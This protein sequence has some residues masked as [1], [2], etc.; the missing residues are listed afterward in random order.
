MTTRP[1]VDIDWE[2][3]VAETRGG[4]KADTANLVLLVKEMRAA[5]GSNYGISMALA[6]DLWYLRYFDAAA[7]QPYLDWFGFMTY[8]LH[9]FWDGENAN[10]GSIVRGQAGI[11]EIQNNTA[12]LWFDGLDFSKINFGLA[13]YG[14]GYTL[15]DPIN[16]K[17][18]GCTFSG[19][20]NAAQCSATKGVMSLT[21]IEELIKSKGLT[22]TLLEAQMM[23]SIQW[24]DQWIG[25][26]DDETFAMKKSWASD[27]CFGGTMAWSVDYY[28]GV[29]SGDNVPLSTDG[30]CGFDA[31]MRCGNDFG[32]CCSSSGWCG[33]DDGH[34]GS[35]CQ[36]TYGNCTVRTLAPFF[37]EG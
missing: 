3:P 19:P 9:G 33:D 25:Y 2:Y 30:T 26:D 35:G 8:D 29:G 32:A 22:P 31:Q 20:N 10:I 4:N 28:S 21:E 23:K 5:F 11:D 7:M 13:Y 1:G 18:L 6:P 16:C 34:C 37:S 36:S 12:P 14:R 27:Y 15:A 24:A 17:G